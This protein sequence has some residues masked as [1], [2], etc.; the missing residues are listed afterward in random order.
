MRLYSGAFESFFNDGNDLVE[1]LAGSEFG[2]HTAET[3]VRFN[4]GSDNRRNDFAA[5][6]HNSGGGF[7]AGRFNSEHEHE[8]ILTMIRLCSEGALKSP[9]KASLTEVMTAALPA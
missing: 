3:F 1:M 4:L 6:V 9:S 5:V 2:N 7:I 8:G